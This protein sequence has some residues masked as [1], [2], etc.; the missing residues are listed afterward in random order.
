MP[1]VK[2]SKIVPKG[3]EW[4]EEELKTRYSNLWQKLHEK[5]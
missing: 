1:K 3:K 5:K 2:S 4:K